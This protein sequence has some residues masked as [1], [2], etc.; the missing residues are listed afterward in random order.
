MHCRVVRQGVHM[1]TSLRGRL[2]F[3][4]WLA[5]SKPTSLSN[6]KKLIKFELIF[7]LMYTKSQIKG[8]KITGSDCISFFR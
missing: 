7:N 6:W 8:P 4:D 1:Y 5:S 2:T 3:K